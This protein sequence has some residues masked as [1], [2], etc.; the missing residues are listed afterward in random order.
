MRSIYHDHDYFIFSFTKFCVIFRFFTK[1]LTLGTLFSR[2]VRAAVVAKLVKVGNSP[3][4]SLILALREELVAKLIILD[5]SPLT[6]FQHLET[7]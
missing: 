7:H 5:I 4:T 1:L 6:S 2:A 3:L